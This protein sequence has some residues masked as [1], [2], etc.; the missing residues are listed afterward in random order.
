MHNVLKVSSKR[1]K[2]RFKTQVLSDALG[3]STN[4]VY[5]VLCTAH[6]THRIINTLFYLGLSNANSKSKKS[7]VNFRVSDKKTDK[8]TN[9]LSKFFFLNL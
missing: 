7:F 5:S 1:I 2:D 9:K 6:V 8:L 3:L 4:T